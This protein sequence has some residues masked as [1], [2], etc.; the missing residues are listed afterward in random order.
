MDG[1]IDN[2][3]NGSYEVSKD[4]G[5][6]ALIGILRSYAN[7][8]R[9]KEFGEVVL[10]IGSVFDGKLPFPLDAVSTQSV[11]ESLDRLVDSEILEGIK[12]IS[13][14]MELLNEGNKSSDDVSLAARGFH[15]DSNNLYNHIYFGYHRVHN[16]LKTFKDNPKM[17]EKATFVNGLYSDFEHFRLLALSIAYLASSG[18][19]SRFVTYVDASQLEY[20]LGRKRNNNFVLKRRGIKQ[21]GSIP[22]PV[23]AAANQLAKNAK[24]DYTVRYAESNKQGILTIKDAGTGLVDTSGEQLPA[25]RF[26]E[27]YGD[28]TTRGK[29][30]GLGLQVAKRLMEFSKGYIEVKSRA[31]DGNVYVHSTLTGRVECLGSLPEFKGAE[32]KLYFPKAVGNSAVK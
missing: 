29:D 21:K 31:R 9:I 17:R 4:E 6:H 2:A 3:V 14:Q 20:L 13:E 18:A 12:R 25:D 1:T 19:D 22:S 28:F 23:Y 30:G 32:F 11:A 5:N 15:H 26:H 16:K 24:S 10:Q 27:I 8:L 7:L